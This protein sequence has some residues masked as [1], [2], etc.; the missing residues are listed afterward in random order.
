[1]QHMAGAGQF[2]P[3]Q[4]NRFGM[5]GGQ[6]MDI[7]QFVYQHIANS[8]VGI[9]PGGWQNGVPIAERVRIVQEL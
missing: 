6:S 5:G 8:T 3:Q 7:G 1:M 9:P 4:Q 2:M